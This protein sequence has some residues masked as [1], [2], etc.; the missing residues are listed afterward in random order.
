MPTA[1][2]G[3]AARHAVISS[4]DGAVQASKPGPVSVP[5]TADAGTAAAAADPAGAGTGATAA[6]GMGAA[7]AGAASA[8]AAMAGPS[9]AGRP[10]SAARAGTGTSRAK[11]P[12][13]DR[14]ATFMATS[15]RKTAPRR[16]RC[17]VSGPQDM[18]VCNH[19]REV[20]SAGS[21]PPDQVQ[22]GGRRAMGVG[23]PGQRPRQE[24]G[25][26][27][28]RV[29]GSRGPRRRGGGEQS[30]AVP[31]LDVHAPAGDEGGQ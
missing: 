21:A 17:A 18:S 14:R 5:G 16:A 12:A 27:F 9:S 31:G 11:A 8:G 26:P 2:Y 28:V 1:W 15:T 3:D 24:R 22:Q 10:S 4:G 7:S 13:P 6:D 30:H 23:A 19:Y 25:A 20:Q 29:V